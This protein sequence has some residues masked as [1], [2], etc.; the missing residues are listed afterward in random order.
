MVFSSYTWTKILLFLYFYLCLT[1]LFTVCVVC[2]TAAT[3]SWIY[4]IGVDPKPEK[5]WNAW[6]VNNQTAGYVT[7]FDLGETD[8]S[9]LFVTVHGAGHE[10]PAYRPVEAL[11]LFKSYFSGEWE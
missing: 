6:H 5:F 8:S 7:E 3:Q 2:S 10:V 9:F 11:S 1:F 4:N